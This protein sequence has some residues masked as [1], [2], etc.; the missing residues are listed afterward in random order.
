MRKLFICLLLI[1]FMVPLKS[2]S[3]Y[4]IMGYYS[5]GAYDDYVIVYGYYDANGIF[6]LS[7]CRTKQIEGDIFS[8]FYTLDVNTCAFR[9]ID[10]PEGTAT[11]ETPSTLSV[12]AP[13]V[14]QKVFSGTP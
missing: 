8:N 11:T 3:E 14:G 7:H 12:P 9:R 10:I 6:T 1:A 5:N 4:Q 2:D 13:P